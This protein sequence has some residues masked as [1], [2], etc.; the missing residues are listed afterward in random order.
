MKTKIALICLFLGS[1]LIPSCCKDDATKPVM[2]ILK[3]HISYW[4][5]VK[6]GV[7]IACQEYNITCDIRWTDSDGD[8]QSQIDAINDYKKNCQDYSALVIAP[9]NENVCDYLESELS[10]N[11]APLIIMDTPVSSGSDLKYN[12]YVGTNNKQAGISLAT[13]AKKDIPDILDKDVVIFKLATGDSM[14]ERASGLKSVITN[15]IIVSISE[16]EAEAIATIKTN[17]ADVYFGTNE[18]N[19]TFAA[20]AIKDGE[21]NA[22]P[23]YGF[24]ESDYIVERL[25]DGTITGTMIQKSK[26]MGYMAVVN[27]LLQHG[28]KNN[29]NRF[30]NTEYIS[31]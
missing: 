4:E 31:Y 11:E 1:L 2:V 18:L 13:Q 29:Q 7:D 24:D 23:L 5:S 22:K 10:S 9:A 12:V 20:K 14:A 19:T 6:S 25:Q 17:I 30:L 21:I 3:N 16:V 8:H 27:A 26:E 15:A 28:D